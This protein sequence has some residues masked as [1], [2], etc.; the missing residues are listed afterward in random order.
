MQRFGVVGIR[1]GLDTAEQAE[2]VFSTVVLP[3]KPKKL[4]KLERRSRALRGLV[5]VG[6]R[7]PSIQEGSYLGEGIVEDRI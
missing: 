1:V 3:K 4:P 5:K 6:S 7:V 2:G